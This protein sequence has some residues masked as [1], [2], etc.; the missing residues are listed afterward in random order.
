M[1]N[2]L[3]YFYGMLDATGYE[4]ISTFW[5]DFSIADSFGKEAVKDTYERAFE[6]WKWDYKYL[7]ELV[8]V[9]NWKLW[10]H[11]EHWSKILADVYND[12]WI[13][14][15]DYACQNLKDEELSY[16]YRTTD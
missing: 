6:E 2:Q 7:T 12:L 3:N 16:Y 9:L 14:T 4:P 15:H 8:L 1:N 10:F 13:K 5:M 11:Y